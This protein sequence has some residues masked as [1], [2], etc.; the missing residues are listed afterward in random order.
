[1]MMMMSNSNDDNNNNSGAP[2][3]GN[4]NNINVRLLQQQQ[5]S[6][7]QHKKDCEPARRQR[8]EDQVSSVSQKLQKIIDTVQQKSP[9]IIWLKEVWQL[10]LVTHLKD[11]YHF[12]QF[13]TL[14]KKTKVPLQVL[15]LSTEFRQES[16]RCMSLSRLDNILSARGLTRQSIVTW[17]REVGTSE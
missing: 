10:Q 17:A 7:K 5:H 11:T 2:P 15:L 6:D 12:Q 16:C 13:G 14:N 3:A 4:N 8:V 9:G 1:M